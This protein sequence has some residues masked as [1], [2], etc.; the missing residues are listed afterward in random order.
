MASRV[1]VLGIGNIERGDDG[2]G[3]AVARLLRYMLSAPVEI[4]EQDG[5][6]TALLAKLDGAAS[7][8]LIDACVSNAPAGTVHRIDA[9][10]ASL[11]QTSSD[12]STHGFGLAAAIELGRTLGQLPPRTIVY[13]IEAESFAAGAPLSEPVATA[14]VIV[15]DRIRSEIEEISP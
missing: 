13:A 12:L 8:Y 11:P 5:E 15:A 14:T 10:H 7:A 6:A 1:I 3:R 4:V 2:A 9:N